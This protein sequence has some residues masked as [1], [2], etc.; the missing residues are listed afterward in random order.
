M[1]LPTTMKAVILK[2]SYRVAVEDVP[3]PKIKEDG[4]VLVKVHLAG[5][6]GRCISSSAFQCMNFAVSWLRG[7]DERGGSSG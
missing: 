2:G 7:R 5:L 4:D 6:C 3:V 1:S